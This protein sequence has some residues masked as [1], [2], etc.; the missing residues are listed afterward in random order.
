MNSHGKGICGVSRLYFLLNDIACS[1]WRQVTQKPPIE[2]IMNVVYV[3]SWKRHYKGATQLD[4][5]RHHGKWTQCKKKEKRNRGIEIELVVYSS[6]LCF[7]VNYQKNPSLYLSC[8]NYFSFSCLE[9]GGVIVVFTIVTYI[10]KQP[11]LCNTKKTNHW[12]LLKLVYHCIHS[13]C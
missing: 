7:I 8:F 9:W 10:N 5:T 3:Q 1:P 11:T 2:L 4:W 12:I 6:V 13:R